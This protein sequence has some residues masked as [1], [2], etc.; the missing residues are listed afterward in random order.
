MQQ[1]TIGQAVSCSGVGL[2]KGGKVSM[3]FYPAPANTGV[4]FV[5]NTGRGRRFIRADPHKV[6]DTNLATGLSDGEYGI[7]TVEHVLA[8][9]TGTGVDNIHIEVDDSEVPIMDGSAASFVY[10]LQQAGFVRQEARKRV[11]ILKRPFQFQRDGK[12]ISA[13]PAAEL[14]IR[15]TIDYDHPLIGKQ[16]L[17]FHLRDTSFVQELCKARTFA[18]LGDV[19]KMRHSGRALGGSLDNALV[20]DV[21]S[22]VNHDGMRYPDEP[23]RHKALDFLGD[24]GLLPYAIKGHFEVYCSGHELNNQFCR[25]LLDNEAEFLDCCKVPEEHGSEEGDAAMWPVPGENPA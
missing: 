18:F 21:S 4:I 25:H 11:Y 12:F 6:H 5:L 9:L 3:T 7:G 13:T 23:V 1:T 8:A 24:L 20:L 15:Y 17:S 2:H 16:Q 10:L 14:S 22:V 19:E